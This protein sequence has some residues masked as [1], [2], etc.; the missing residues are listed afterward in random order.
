MV[1]TGGTARPSSRSGRRRGVCPLTTTAASRDTPMPI[2]AA[3][4]PRL[5]TRLICL[6]VGEDQSACGVLLRAN[7]SVN[8]I[9]GTRARMTRP[10][11]TPTPAAAQVASHRSVPALPVNPTMAAAVN[12]TREQALRI[13]GGQTG[14]TATMATAAITA[15]VRPATPMSPCGSSR[16]S[17]EKAMRGRNERTSSSGFMSANLKTPGRRD[18]SHSADLR[19]GGAGDLDAGAQAGFLQ[20]VRDV[21]L[22]GP[23]RDEQP[24]ADLP[25]GQPVADQRD[26]P[27]LGG[28]Q[29]GPAEVGVAVRLAGAA[30][31][32]QGP[33]PSQGALPVR[34]GAHP[35]VPGQGGVQG[36]GGAVPVP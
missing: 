35:L 26:D 13:L 8:G 31:Q 27:V 5:R 19:G 9:T 17:T 24:G 3:P 29:A 28:G 11:T 23:R 12:S 18:I 4:Q 6:N 20:D 2:R 10:M 7:C 33:E 34:D 15:A 14:R 36:R 25:V 30:A 21:G 16:A 1:I 32:A 22:H